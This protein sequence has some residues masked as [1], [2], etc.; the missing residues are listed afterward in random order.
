MW[1]C[2]LTDHVNQPNFSV[3]YTVMKSDAVVHLAQWQY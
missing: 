2:I 1:G 3:G